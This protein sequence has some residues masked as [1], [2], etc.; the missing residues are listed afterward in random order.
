MNEKAYIAMLKMYENKLKEYMSE[1]EYT[2]FAEE[3][4]KGVF[5][6]EVLA[7]PNDEF[8]KMVADNWDDITA[9]MEEEE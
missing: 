7:S 9:P 1:E 6:A 8:K 5:L 3:V 2:K 4:A